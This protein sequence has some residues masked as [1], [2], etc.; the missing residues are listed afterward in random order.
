MTPEGS[1]RNDTAEPLHCFNKNDDYEK[2]KPFT[3][4]YVIRQS[5]VNIASHLVERS[6]HSVTPQKILAAVDRIISED[7]IAVQRFERN[8]PC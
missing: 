2:C 4:L 5:S 7:C 6:S 8:Q 1:F 3:L